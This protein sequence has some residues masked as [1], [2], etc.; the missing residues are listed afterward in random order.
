MG[1]AG[2][3]EAIQRFREIAVVLLDVALPELDAEGT[4]Q[5]RR[6]IRPEVPVVFMSGRAD[7]EVADRLEGELHAQFLKKP[8]TLEQ[9]TRTRSRSAPVV[10]ATTL[11]RSL[12]TPTLALCA[13]VS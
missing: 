11:T 3:G 13:A 10:G 4:F 12:P 2:G 7:D 1:T 6:R 5:R 9:L 8:F